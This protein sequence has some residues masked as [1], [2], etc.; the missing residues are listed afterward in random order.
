MKRHLRKHPQ[1]HPADADSH[2]A[3]S[4]RLPYGLLWIILTLIVLVLVIVYD[5]RSIH[6]AQ[7]HLQTGHD[8]EKKGLFMEALREYDQAFANRRL[9]RKAKAGAAVA[10]AEI[11]FQHLEDYP[12]ANRYYVQA[13]QMSPGAMESTELQSHAKLA[14]SRSRGAGMIGNRRVRAD[15]GTTA[16]I[17]QRVQLLEQPIADQRGPVLATFEGG[18]IRAGEILRLLQHRP[19]FN[20]PSFRSD[21]QKLKAF[22]DTV[23]REDLAYAAGIQAG[24]HKD[25][26]VST[27][28]YDYQKQL[29]TQRYMMERKDLALRVDNADVEKYYKDHQ[30]EF[31]KPGKAEVSLIKTD[32]QSSATAL[33][34]MLRGGARFDTVAT[35]YSMDLASSTK[36]GYAGEISETDTAIPGVGEA[37]DMVKDLLK[38]PVKT[39][40]DVVSYK[41]AYYIFKIDSVQPA[42]H[43]TLDE[44]RGR[45]ENTLRGQAV[46]AVRHKLDSELD[47]Q[48]HPHVD[49]KA[50]DGFW[51]FVQKQTDAV[52]RVP[53][54]EGTTAT[55]AGVTT[56]GASVSPTS[57]TLESRTT[58]GA[59]SG[60]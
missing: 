16:T 15:D 1:Q 20:S 39:I 26:D 10:M 35:S 59:A 57:I 27:R 49:D 54:S 60:L 33:L 17:V 31:V 13:R 58:S 55:A 11:Y 22:L 45:I 18:E 21:P 47:S 44:A 34:N 14:A 4:G 53:F 29:I 24:I 2:T 30:S 7:Q 50:L 41:D 25:P 3:G 9:G 56:A 23:L 19:E 32:N 40:S 51:Q 28:L 43:I 37:P 36:R 42:V 46:D 52:A 6:D 12:S 48:F 5:R 38:L 8:L